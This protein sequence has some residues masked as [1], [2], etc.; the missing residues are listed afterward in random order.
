MRL[1][2]LEKAKKL[3]DQGYSIDY[4]AGQLYV[5]PQTMRRWLR[6][7]ERYGASLCG[8]YP[9]EVQPCSQSDLMS[10]L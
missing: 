5:H 7:Y 6:N 3:R 4:V 10:E 1:E 2:Q 8:D 9:V